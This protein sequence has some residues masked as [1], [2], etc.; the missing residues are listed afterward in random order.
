MDGYRMKR[1]AQFFFGSTHTHTHTH[2]HTNIYERDTHR[3]RIVEVLLIN[4]YQFLQEWK[5]IIEPYISSG[6]SSSSSSIF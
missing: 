2:T 4:E 6:S 1:E 5:R 3:E